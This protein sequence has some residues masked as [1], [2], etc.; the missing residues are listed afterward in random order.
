[1]SVRPDDP[2]NRRKRYL[3]VTSVANLVLL[4]EGIRLSG[5]EANVATLRQ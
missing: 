1:M 5:A 4:I 3:V 2:T